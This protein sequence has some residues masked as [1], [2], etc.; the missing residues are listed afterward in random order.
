MR[1]PFAP[2]WMMLQVAVLAT[3][4]AVFWIGWPTP[5]GVTALSRA[6]VAAPASGGV[7]TIELPDDWRTDGDDALRRSYEFRFDLPAIPPAP[8][9]ILLPSVRMHAAASINGHPLGDT[10]L[11]DGPVARSWHRP[12][13]YTIPPGLLVQGTNRL[14]VDVA[15]ANPGAGYLAPPQVAPLAVLAPVAAGR[16]LLQQTLILVIIGTM[17]AVAGLILL[18]WLMRRESVFGL[19]ALGM[20]VW[21]VHTLNF[22]VVTPP[23]SQRLWETGAYLTLGLFTALATCFVH[24][25]LGIRRPAMEVLAFAIVLFSLPV[26]LLIPE[27]RFAAF[28]DGPF[29]AAIMAVG[30]YVL[31]NFHVE[32]WRRRSHE[33]QVLAASGTVVVVFALHDTLVG[34]GILPWGSGY[35]L[36]YSASVVLLAFSA[37]LVGRLARSLAT[38]ERMNEVMNERIDEA[39]REL[40]EGHRRVRALER[41]RLLGR[42]RDRIARDMHDGVGGQLIALL[43][44]ARAGHLSGTDAQAGLTSAIEDLRLVIDSLETPEGD[45]ATALAK[46]RHRLERRLRGCGITLA[47]QPGEAAVKRAFRPA[48]I[49]HVLRL[50]D[51]AA[52]NALSHAGATEL[53]MGWEQDGDELRIRFTDN[54]RGGLHGRPGGKGVHNMHERARLLG[55]ELRVASDAAGTRL[56]LVIPSF[57][58]P[59]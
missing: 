7:Q 11:L 22:V 2:T 17:A 45:L 42:E 1:L 33:L 23:V 26:L 28:G 15:A 57:S 39:R 38:V 41:V 58:G 56:L 50:F 51:E 49:L 16:H 35:V 19:Y 54:G 31:A 36:H 21:A 5:A 25:Y 59:D 53:V 24:R 9:A 27:G 18:L 32:A 46:F 52:S 34:L 14:R 13:L 55:A 44:R 12:L 43:A 8:W 3:A 30:F 40:A 37:L 4:M 20:A 10:T 29:N 47:W 6:E 48:E